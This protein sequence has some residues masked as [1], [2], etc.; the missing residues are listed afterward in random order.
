M[1]TVVETFTTPGTDNW[2]CP[3]NYVAGSLTAELWGAGGG[4]GGGVT[5]GLN[6]AGAGGGYSKYHNTITVVAGNSYSYNL[7]A[8]GI[9]GTNSVAG[10]T[11]SGFTNFATEESDTACASAPGGGGSTIAAGS[12]G[13]G[14][15]G[16]ASADVA[17]TGGNGARIGS[18]TS[19]G[20]AG[21][22]AGTAANG[23]N[24]SGTTGGDPVTGGGFGG[25]GGSTGN[26]GSAGGN[27]G[28]GGGSA[29]TNTGGNGG[30][31]GN[32][33]I[34]LTYQT[35]SGV[36]PTITSNGAGATA[37]ISV[38]EMT[39]A[40]TTVVASGDATM[41]YTKS[42]T[43]AGKF[44]IGSS[45]GVLTFTTPPDYETPTDANADNVYLVTV[46]AT[47]GV[48]S[49]AQ[50][51]SVTV[52][53]VVI[54]VNAVAP[55]ISG[56]NIPGN[57]QSS[58]HG[59]WSNTP[60][61]YTYQWRVSDDASDTNGADIGA[62]T[63]QS[64]TI[65]TAHGGRYLRCR[66]S[67]VN[68]EGTGTA[69]Y[70]NYVHILAAVTVPSTTVFGQL[71]DVTPYVGQYVYTDHTF[72][73]PVP[74]PMVRDMNSPT[75][76]LDLAFSAVC[77]NRGGV[78]YTYN[79]QLISPSIALVALHVTGPNSVFNISVTGWTWMQ[80]DGTEIARTCT[81]TLNSDCWLLG[82]D[83]LVV[84]LNAPITTI[85]PVP[86]LANSSQVANATGLIGHTSQQLNSHVID[87]V[88]DNNQTL[89]QWSTNATTSGRA[90]FVLV[91]GRPVL[92]GS[93]VWTTAYAPNPS[94]WL[95][96]LAAIA[97]SVGEQPRLARIGASPM[98]SGPILPL[99]QASSAASIASPLQDPDA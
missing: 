51:L 26:N 53:N 17:H 67:G 23:N 27:P 97:G 91:G 11:P 66:T 82:T 70:S 99:L 18:G 33:K 10:G 80:P 87:G 50:D 39:T 83:L 38:P 20:G 22:S 88:T 54:P 56:V 40:V 98:S 6:G 76:N 30:A 85:T 61:S 2:T 57:A 1:S 14:D 34:V 81:F 63:S 32:G 69:A 90:P 92:F 29:G 41:T 73:H 19:G 3:A 78:R 13:A 15:V 36:A 8:G 37:S 46:T 28:G 93:A 59:T 75:T 16:D 84:K 35:S 47:N 77:Q 7:V 48:G 72:T 45:T 96:E 12:G 94:H 24:G 25:D 68:S 31:G 21:S 86:I 44:T 64:Y 79:A 43:D 89:S 9:A 42:G 52:T 55:V 62:A 60:T 95:A 74:F 71:A 58:D 65:L 5:G 4:G 49:D